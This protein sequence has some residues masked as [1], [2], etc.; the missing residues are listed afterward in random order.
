MN[1]EKRAHD[2]TMLILHDHWNDL[3]EYGIKTKSKS[4]LLDVY[5]A[6]YP[7]ILA[8]NQLTMKRAM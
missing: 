1:D 4:Y 3:E 6:L 2:L 5:A 7:K 8:M